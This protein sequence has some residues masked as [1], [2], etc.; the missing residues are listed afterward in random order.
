MTTRDYHVKLY[1]DDYGQSYFFKFTDRKGRDHEES[2]GSYT[3]ID[4]EDIKEYIYKRVYDGDFF[5]NL[6][7][8]FYVVFDL[9]H[10]ILIDLYKKIFENVTEKTEA[11]A[12][13]YIKELYNECD[14]KLGN[15]KDEKRRQWNIWYGELDRIL[16]SF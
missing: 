13:E 3:T 8:R 10:E 5:E 11:E 14:R 2:G 15:I 4:E 1:L 16:C 12:R 9:D 6:R 7:K